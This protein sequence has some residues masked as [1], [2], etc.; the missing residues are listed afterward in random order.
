[1]NSRPIKVLLLILALL[2]SAYSLW[3]VYWMAQLGFNFFRWHSVLWFYIVVTLLLG[4]ALWVGH[5]W[6][7]PRSAKGVNVGGWIVLT[8]AAICLMEFLLR[9]MGPFEVYS[10]KRE[11]YY[12]SPFSLL[13]KSWFYVY[14]ANA[15]K[16]LKSGDEYDYVRHTNSLGLS[17]KEWAVQKDSGTIRILALG[18]SFTE[19]DGA[20]AD[21]SYPALLAQLLPKAYPSLHIEVMNA[22]ACGSDPYFEYMLLK[23]KLTA[24][25]P[26]IV[27]Y[28]NSENDLLLDYALYGGME[29]FLPN[30][31]IQPRLQKKIWMDVYAISH[32]FRAIRSISRGSEALLSD[33]EVKQAKRTMYADSK[34]LSK[35]YSQLAAANGFQCVQLIRPN[36]QEFKAA[37]YVF[38]PDS[39]LPKE[40]LPRYR[41]VD[42]LSIYLD[43]LGTPSQAG[44]K[45]Y[46][47]KDGHHNATGYQLMA[48]GVMVALRPLLDSLNAPTATAKAK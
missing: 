22:G 28:T 21:S 11:G 26:D 15:L 10:E 36:K 8:W 44:D 7:K 42:L 34:H 43:T 4:A 23:H 2:F 41:Q 39:L 25:R 31:A 17:D 40:D 5:T 6:W 18:D 19:G 48:E 37:A 3:R 30:G 38:S 14:H 12:Y 32:I 29:R 24:Y 45:Y 16:L 47:K 27:L 20:P 35:L 33:S 9:M 1:M 13:N 46:W